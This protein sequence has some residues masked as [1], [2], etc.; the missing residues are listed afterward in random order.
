MADNPKDRGPADRARINLNQ[1]HE[2]RYWTDA[3]GCTEDQLKAA[4][5]KAGPMVD[6]VRAALKK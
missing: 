1:D 4:V 5:K 3:L 6:D 2:V